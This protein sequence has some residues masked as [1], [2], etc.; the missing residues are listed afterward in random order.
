MSKPVA[1]VG[2]RRAADAGL[3]SRRRVRRPEGKTTSTHAARRVGRRWSAKVSNL[4]ALPRRRYG[5]SAGPP[6]RAPRAKVLSWNLRQSTSRFENDESREKSCLKTHVSH[7]RGRPSGPP[8]SGSA[9]ESRLPAGPFAT[10][11]G[12]RGAPRRVGFSSSTERKSRRRMSRAASRPR[13]VERLLTRLEGDHLHDGVAEIPEI[14]QIFELHA[15]GREGR[16]SRLRGR[17]A[18]RRA[19]N[20]DGRASDGGLPR[21][22]QRTRMGAS[23][24]LRLRADVASKLGRQLHGEPL[25]KTKRVER[26]EEKSPHQKEM[27]SRPVD[28]NRVLVCVRAFFV[29]SWR[30]NAG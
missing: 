29:V 18:R 8:G 25:D 10:A 20:R 7:R 30:A 3:P 17:R 22:A 15:A 13:E 24:G 19:M 1:D 9:I 6:A 14:A 26:Q 23:A 27:S 28:L 11:F 16:T 5:P 12:R 4:W 2:G 21:A